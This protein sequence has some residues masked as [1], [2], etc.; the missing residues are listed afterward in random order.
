MRHDA[1]DLDFATCNSKMWKFPLVV[2]VSILRSAS[3]SPRYST[4]K[5]SRARSRVRLLA[6]PHTCTQPVSVSTS[7][8]ERIQVQ[9]SERLS[10]H[11]CAVYASMAHWMVDLAI[12]VSKTSAMLGY[13]TDWT[14]VCGI[15]RRRQ[16]QDNVTTY[17]D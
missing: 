17:E 15:V 2:M 10:S 11:R 8:R 16:V 7:S 6:R 13:A 14:I 3:T 5:C 1:G 9:V 12:H 4:A